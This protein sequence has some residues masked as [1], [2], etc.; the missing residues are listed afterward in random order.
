MFAPR[1]TYEASPR[2][3][4]LVAAVVA[5]M[6]VL[7]PAVFG[8]AAMCKR[9]ASQAAVP[10]SGASQADAISPLPGAHAPL[11]Q[12]VTLQGEALVPQ[13]ATTDALRSLSDEWAD[14]FDLLAASALTRLLPAVASAGVDAARAYVPSPSLLPP[15]L[16]DLSSVV[17]LL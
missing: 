13:Y 5:V 8:S 1:S 2:S 3:V 7:G 16:R 17:L 15:A 4:R 6:L 10:A 11:L 9:T 14:A 12:C